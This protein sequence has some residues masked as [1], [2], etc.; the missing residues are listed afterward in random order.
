MRADDPTLLDAGLLASSRRCACSFSGQFSGHTA[1]WFARLAKA[2]PGNAEW[3]RDLYVS[4]D[5]ISKVLVDQG[6]LPAALDGYK[7]AS[8]PP[9]AASG[10][11]AAVPPMSAMN[12]RRLIIRSP[13]RRG[14]AALAALRGRASVRSGG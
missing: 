2:D 12:S 3:R 9:R 13:R 4:H 10:H 1:N 8:R 7:A 14:R 6:N 11:A 5:R